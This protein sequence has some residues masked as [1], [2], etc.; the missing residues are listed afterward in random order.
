MFQTLLTAAS[1]LAAASEAATMALARVRAR[2]WPSFPALV[3]H[4]SAAFW[5]TGVPKPWA[6]HLPNW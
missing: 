1:R 4:Q 5:S 3:K 2:A 6:W